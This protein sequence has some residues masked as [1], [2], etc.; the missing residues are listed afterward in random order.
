M[1]RKLTLLSRQA[2]AGSSLAPLLEI[3]CSCVVLGPML[4]KKSTSSVETLVLVQCWTYVNKLT[5]T[6]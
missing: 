5:M 3:H 6:C 2:C 4:G 1:L